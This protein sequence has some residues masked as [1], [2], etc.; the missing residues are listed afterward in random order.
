MFPVDMCLASDGGY[1]FVTKTSPVISHTDQYGETLWRHEYHLDPTIS[2]KATASGQTMDGGYV[3]S[4][5]DGYFEGPWDDSESGGNTLDYMEGWLVRFDADGNELWNINNTVSAN[6]H[7]Y[8][9]L[10]LPEGGYM[11]CGTW[12]GSG[13]LVR[14]APETG[15]E[16]GGR[17]S[18][19]YT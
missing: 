19:H 1:I 2:T 3:F 18:R 6:H 8:S 13:Y 12:G 17:S 4:G 7:F 5:W 14:Y 15:I 16:G 10:Q 11:A 9:C